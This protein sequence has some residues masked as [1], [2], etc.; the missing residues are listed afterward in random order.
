MGALDG[1]GDDNDKDKP[2]TEAKTNCPICG[3]EVTLGELAAHVSTH[4][5][6]PRKP[7]V[8]K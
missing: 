5:A 6:P 4:Q 7:K 2:I 8:V 3:A 1:G